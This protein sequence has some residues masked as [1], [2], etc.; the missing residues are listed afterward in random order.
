MLYVWTDRRRTGGSDRLRNEYWCSGLEGMA[1]VAQAHTDQMWN[2]SS[3][4][5][6]CRDS[7]LARVRQE[8]GSMGMSLAIDASPLEPMYLG[9]VAVFTFG[10]PRF[11]LAA[12]ERCVA[13][14]SNIL[15]Q[16]REYQI[17]RTGLA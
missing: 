1:V 16:A 9:N 4:Y 3:W 6:A 2:L 13:F 12:R 14:T 11:C 7:E 17:R 8:I 10:P 15:L 5:L